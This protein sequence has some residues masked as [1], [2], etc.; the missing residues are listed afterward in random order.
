MPQSMIEE[1]ALPSDV[2]DPGR[3]A[4]EI[5]NEIGKLGITRDANQYV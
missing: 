5:A 3:D 4:F 2:R 1:I